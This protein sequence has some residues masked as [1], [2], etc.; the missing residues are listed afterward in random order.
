MGSSPSKQAESDAHKSLARL[1]KVSEKHFYPDTATPDLSTLPQLQ[2]L[3]DIEGLDLSGNNNEKDIANLLGEWRASFLD[4][5]K[6]RLA[7]AALSRSDYQSLLIRN[8]RY[9][10]QNPAVFT[11]VIKYDGQKDTPVT[12]QRSSGR[13]WLFASTNV[14]RVQL[15]KSSNIKPKDFQ[16]SQ[17]YLFFYDKLEKAS[18]FLEQIIDTADE[19][20]DSRLVQELLKAP[21]NDGGQWDMVVNLVEKYG[22]V[23]QDVFPDSWNAQNSSHLNYLLTNKLREYGLALRKLIQTENPTPELLLSLRR[24]YT[25]NV[26]NILATSLGVPPAANETFKWDYWTIDDKP[27]QLTTTPTK[28]YRENLKYPASQY[29]S[30]INDPRNN[31]KQLYTVDRLQNISG[32]RP[33]TYVNADISELKKAAIKMIQNNEPVFFGSD[34]GQY[35]DRATGILDPKSWDYD[36]GFNTSLG[37]NK[38]QRVSTGASSM[39]HAM[40]ITGVHLE[41]GVPV[42]WKIENSWG[43]D[44]GKKGYFQMSDKW[45]DEYVFQ[46][47]SSA[48]Y[49]PRE[50]QQVLKSKPQVLPLWDPMGALA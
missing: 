30:L 11:H 6:N 35:G 10:D 43:A 1:S 36:L 37:M 25:Q 47:V 28:F 41:D 20:L 22:L 24:Q 44:S 33:I 48:Q 16:F 12:N 23:P 45:F 34:V 39:T 17:A 14:F 26:Y 19:D 4:S 13:C 5:P 27:Q 31:Y 49:V 32:G 42:K 7:L 50:L 29:F 21:V 46:V 40:V 18:Y 2:L 15:I 9:N 8:D 3:P 38:E